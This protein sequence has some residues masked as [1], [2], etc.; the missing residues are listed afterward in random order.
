MKALA[1]T[2]FIWIFVVPAATALLLIF[3]LLAVVVPGC[4]F[5]CFFL[6]LASYSFLF[7]FG[8]FWYSPFRFECPLCSST[9]HTIEEEKND[10]HQE[11]EVGS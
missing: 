1:I 6:V 4:Y 2:L 5:P 8:P 9:T 10:E 3:G 11:V 7:T